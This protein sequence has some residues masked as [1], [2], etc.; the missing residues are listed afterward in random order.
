MLTD[1]PFAH[2]VPRPTDD[3]A[4]AAMT[5]GLAHTLEVAELPH[6]G[7]AAVIVGPCQRQR[8]HLDGPQ[9]A[10]LRSLLELM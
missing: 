9:L 7:G 10:Q 6:C 8:R 5:D 2:Y 1:A 3:V 4:S